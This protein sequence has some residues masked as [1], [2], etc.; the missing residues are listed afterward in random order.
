MPGHALA[1]WRSALLAHPLPGLLRGVALGWTLPARRA[2]ARTHSI[3]KLAS[4]G[5]EYLLV[6]EF[7]L[8]DRVRERDSQIGR[9]TISLF[10]GDFVRY[11]ISKWRLFLAD[12]QSPE[13]GGGVEQERNLGKFSSD[14]GPVRLVF[15]IEL[16]RPSLGVLHSGCFH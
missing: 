1:R 9:W 15:P 12:S 10:K 11:R 4:R 6:G 8:K 5:S 16:K 3:A 14:K 13:P 7:N 2:A